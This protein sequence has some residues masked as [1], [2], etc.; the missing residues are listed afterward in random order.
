LRFFMRQQD[1]GL[2]LSKRRTRK[3]ELLELMDS[4]V[5][6]PE[7][8]AILTAVAPVKAAGRPP[9]AHET[10]LPRTWCNNSLG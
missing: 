1:L 9:F 5:P 7:L 3:M 10:M 4:V 8:V 6:W 2:D